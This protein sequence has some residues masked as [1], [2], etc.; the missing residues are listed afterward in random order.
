MNHK[1]TG[2]KLPSNDQV[3]AVL[4]YSTT[5]E[6]IV[7]T[8]GKQYILAKEELSGYAVSKKEINVYI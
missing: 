5:Y 4:F 3:L 7:C 8:F 2:S 6:K 1:I